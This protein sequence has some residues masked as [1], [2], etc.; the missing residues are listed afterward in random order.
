MPSAVARREITQAWRSAPFDVY[1]ATETAG[2]SSP[3]ALGNRHTYDGLIILEPVDHLDAP[4]PVGTTGARLWVTGL[5]CRTLPLIRY[6]LSD[7]V[8]L[9]G[10]GCPC[11]RPFG[12]KAGVERRSEDV[13]SF[14]SQEGLVRVHPNMFYAVLDELTVAR[15]Q[16]VHE[17]DALRILLVTSGTPINE[18]S[19]RR[20][21]EDAMR[22]SGIPQIHVGVEMVD[23]IPRSAL[24]KTPLVLG[25]Y[26]TDRSGASTPMAM[27]ARYPSTL[28]ACLP[29]RVLSRSC[30]S[31]RS[32]KVQRILT[33]CS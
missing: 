12:L 7:Q 28:A 22:T 30:L 20:S 11:G 21:I 17:T 2:I 33:V 19:V 27:V 10:R 14:P 25:G 31:V 26:R 9:A 4:V 23:S 8:T 15:W 13:L 16:V 18:V 5:C 1:A 32:P 24:G 3:G 6:E 29:I